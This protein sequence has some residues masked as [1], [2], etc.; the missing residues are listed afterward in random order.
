MKKKYLYFLSDLWVSSSRASN[1]LNVTEKPGTHYTA[2]AGLFIFGRYVNHIF[3]PSQ[4]T[5]TE[6][7]PNSFLRYFIF[8]E[9][10][11]LK[12]FNPNKMGYTVVNYVKIIKAFPELGFGK[13]F[14][15][16]F[17]TCQLTIQTTT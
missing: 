13:G 17:V 14:D 12:I 7:Y 9:R 15:D 2:R 5:R 8:S 4:K 6:R 10:L 3:L 1:I 11:Y 16:D